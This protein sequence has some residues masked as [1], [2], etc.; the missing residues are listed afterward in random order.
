MLRACFCPCRCPVGSP[1]CRR[2]NL[3]ALLPAHILTHRPADDF[4]GGSLGGAGSGSSAETYGGAGGGGRLASL[5]SLPSMEELRRLLSDP[6]QPGA[7]LFGGPER[8][9]SGFGGGSSSAFGGGDDGFGGLGMVPVLQPPASL[10]PP[11]APAAPAALRV[12]VSAAPGGRGKRLAGSGSATPVKRLASGA[13]WD[14]EPAASPRTGKR[15][16][17]SSMSG[18]AWSEG[19]TPRS[20]GSTPRAGASRLRDEGASGGGG[21]RAVRTSEDDDPA[22]VPRSERRARPLRQASLHAQQHAAPQRQAS[23]AATAAAAA[24]GAMEV[25]EDE[26]AA[27]LQQY[28]GVSRHR[29]AALAGRQAGQRRGRAEAGLL[30]LTS[31]LCSPAPPAR[32]HQADTA[33]GG[34]AVAQRAAAVPRGL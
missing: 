31:A 15:H 3:P 4:D 33:L 6:L 1:R 14:A 21:R 32:R 18:D 29:C 10:P 34:V 11:L 27:S 22:Y 7:A 20:S 12:R 30:Q 5:P 17:S 16:S 2:V 9:G 24:P 13:G 26:G 28:R 25:D 23:A 19:G 8:S